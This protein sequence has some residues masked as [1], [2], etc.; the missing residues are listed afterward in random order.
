MSPNRRAI[1]RSTRFDGSSRDTSYGGHRQSADMPAP[2]SHIGWLT[3]MR[4]LS[5]L[6]PLSPT[7]HITFVRVRH[8]Q[9]RR[10]ISPER[11][12]AAPRAF[13]QTRSVTH[14]DIFHRR[15]AMR[16]ADSYRVISLAGR[17]EADTR[18]RPPRAPPRRRS[19]PASVRTRCMRH[20]RAF[21]GHDGPHKYPGHARSRDV[22]A[23]DGR[24]AFSRISTTT[25][26]IAAS[27]VALAGVVMR[28]TVT[29]EGER[30]DQ[31]T[32]V[33]EVVNCWNTAAST[34]VPAWRRVRTE[35]PT[36]PSAT[37]WT[38][39]APHAAASRSAT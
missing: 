28:P 37:A 18:S 34:Y 35:T 38:S 16:T 31:R 11:I 3:P 21:R 24:N 2:P 22:G 36:A 12:A 27:P 15:S 7:D 25:W 8:R 23:H 39:S 9:P 19:G 5:W 10:A 14:G 17:D 29:P 1:I 13:S 32:A 33:S 4:D 20:V 6:P 26:S 30:T